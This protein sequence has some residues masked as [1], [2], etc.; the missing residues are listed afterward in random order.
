[1]YPIF[2]AQLDF[3][4]LIIT[5]IYAFYALGVLLALLLTGNWSDQIGRR[6]ML[7]LGLLFAAGSALAFIGGSSLAVLLLGR[8]LSGISAGI[9]SGTAT[10]A[11]VEW[12]PPKRRGLATVLATAV[13]MIGLGFGPLFAGVIAKYVSAPLLWPF[14]A[15]L[16]VVLVGMIL[17]LLA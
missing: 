14:V 10:V 12:A 6:P 2:Q 11:G 9:Y 8:L 1:L 3:S 17:V 15:H 13:N 16:A 5:V 7:L 4:Q